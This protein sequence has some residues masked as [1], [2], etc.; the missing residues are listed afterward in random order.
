MAWTGSRIRPYERQRHL[1]LY[2]Q[3]FDTLH[4]ATQVRIHWVQ[5]VGAE[6]EDEITDARSMMNSSTL[7]VRSA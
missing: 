2:Q 7:K 1:K 4:Y 6:A 5:D 3:A